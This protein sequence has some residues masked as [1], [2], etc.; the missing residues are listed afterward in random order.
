MTSEAALA[1]IRERMAA[2]RERAEL[3]PASRIQ[4][5]P[6]QYRFLAC[7]S[8]KKLFRQGNQWGGKSTAALYEVR[9][10]C[11]GEH[12][13]L[14]VPAP[15][16]EAWV[17]CAS[18]AQSV[19]IQSKFAALLPRDSLDARTLYD[20]V[21]G[22]RGRNPV[23]MFRNGSIV[24]F[25]TTNQGGLD[26]A[27]ATIDVALFD[28]PPRSPRLF[29]EVTKRLLRRNGVL[30]MAMTPVN[31]GPLGWL[32]ERVDAGEV[33]DIHQPLTADALVPVGAREPIRLDDGTVCD[34]AWIDRVLS[35]TLPHEVPVVVHGEW[36]MRVVGRVFS[37]FRDDLHVVDVPSPA[38][39]RLHLGVDY[40]SRAGKQIALLVAVDDS[41][42][43]PRV[44]VLDESVGSGET[45]IE[46]DAIGIV[47]M[48]RRSGCTWRMLDEAWGDRLYVRG[49]AEKKSNG[50]LMIALGRVLKVA[51]SSLQPQ[52]R[53]VKRGAGHGAGSL[54]AGVRWLHQAMLRPGHF[55]IR[56]RCQRLL[57]AMK[58]WDYTDTDDKDPIDA[59]RYALDTLIFR[60]ARYTRGARVYLY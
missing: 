6:G 8:R 26:L 44:V 31:A 45:T 21:V 18:W 3:D 46:Q 27:G 47:E 42:D 53:T 2:L 4:W 48:L 19:A 15:P 37:A 36:E 17:I 24:R 54:S 28:E 50:D 34:Q 33:A 11:L 16:I 51:P 12:P 40:G 10:R 56:P 13:Y 7:P 57:S 59:L 39:W 25:K 14:R 38:G 22:F 43:Q 35:E 29:G 60:A 55:G 58:A 30:L 41:G 23:A 32:R 49:A 9:A 5:L 52:V 1:G 20:P